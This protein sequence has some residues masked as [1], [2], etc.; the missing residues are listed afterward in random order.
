M[1][2]RTNW[3]KTLLAILA[4]SPF[5]AACG[6]DGNGKD[7]NSSSGS[8]SN[9]VG[10]GLLCFAYLLVSGND[11]CLSYIGSGSSG[12]GSSGSSGGSGGSGSSGSSGTP[13]AF[14]P[15]VEYE[16]N[17]DFLNANPVQ[18]PK[19]TDRDGFIADGDVHDVQ[20]HAD[21]YTFTRTFLRYHAFRLCSDGQKYCDE[22]GEIDT[23][24]AYIDIL[25]Q[26]GR[27]IASSQASDSNY[28]R[29]QLASGVPHYARVVA[30][31]TM[32]TTIKYH[33]VVHEANY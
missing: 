2:R 21:I 32:A 15:I 14:R 29:L 20:D 9:S 22:S 28:L 17:N 24:T 5:L 16:P 19:T 6:D 10:G 3:Q 12:S 4:I 11:E 25:D 26:S 23:L 30:G 7:S 18:F 13:I 1:F 27:V 33:F 31:D 8:S